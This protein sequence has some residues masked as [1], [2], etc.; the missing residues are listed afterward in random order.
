MRPAT[1]SVKKERK[2]LK[3]FSKISSKLLTRDRYI[4]QLKSERLI[5]FILLLRTTR[6]LMA[7]NGL[8]V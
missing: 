2:I 6:L 4:Y 5:F 8:R 3:V 7:T 1:F